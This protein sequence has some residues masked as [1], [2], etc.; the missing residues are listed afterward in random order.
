MNKNLN[1]FSSAHNHEGRQ[2]PGGGLSSRCPCCSDAA[3][4]RWNLTSKNANMVLSLIWRFVL[5]KHGGAVANDF[6]QNNNKKKTLPS[7]GKGVQ[8]WG[9]AIVGAF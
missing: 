3:L 2:E 9:G 7:I 8:N 1:H 6:G 5:R 4:A